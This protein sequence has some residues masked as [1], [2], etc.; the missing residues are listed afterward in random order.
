MKKWTWLLPALLIAGLLLAP[1][2]FGP[3]HSAP[4]VAVVPQKRVTL[5][6]DDGPDP[7]FTPQILDL[8][9][10]YDVHATFF[11]VGKNA[12]AHPEIVQ[13][14]V[15][16]GHALANHTL[17]HPHLEQLNE[18]QVRAELEG[19]DAALTSILGPAAASMHYFRP[20]RGKESAAID[21]AVTGLNKRSVMWNVCVENSKTNTPQ[22]VRERV[23]N[24]VG[25]RGGGILLAHDGELDR[26]LTV[27]S[28]PLILRDL[29][30]AGYQFVTL[31][32]YLD[33]QQ[34]RFDNDSQ[35]AF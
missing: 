6:F 9:D 34:Q 31:D 32:Q 18:S 11:I 23:L 30:A 7:R 33:L 16:E 35:T 5:T 17:T 14:I 12:L 15:R 3:V 2:S 28:L 27:H 8:L 1:Q 26:T 21:R 29:R 22:E 20:P 19:A 13:R 10:E 4:T 24:L 25:K